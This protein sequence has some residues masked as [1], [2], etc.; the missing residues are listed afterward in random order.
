MKFKVTF[1]QFRKFKVYFEPNISFRT[2]SELEAKLKDEKV[3]FSYISGLCIAR[4]PNL[5]HCLQI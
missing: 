5:L 4:N 1:D 2:K 3:H